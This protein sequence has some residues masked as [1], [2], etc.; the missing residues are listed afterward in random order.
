MASVSPVMRGSFEGRIRQDVTP[1]PTLGLCLHCGPG[2]S[3]CPAACR[4][5][6][7]PGSLPRW[8]PVPCLLPALLRGPSIGSVP[9]LPNPLAPRADCG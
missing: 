1:C 8:G 7:G 5:A 4:A 3:P 9:S 6:V 2:P